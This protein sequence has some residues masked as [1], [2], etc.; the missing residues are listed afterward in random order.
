MCL[1]IKSDLAPLSRA[2]H[3]IGFILQASPFSLGQ[4]IVCRAVSD[5]G[6]RALSATSRAGSCQRVKQ[7]RAQGVGRDP[8][9]CFY[10][11]WTR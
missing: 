5:L 6:F 3:V 10:Q 2:L 4:L 11:F 1:A 9:E 7:A 8:R